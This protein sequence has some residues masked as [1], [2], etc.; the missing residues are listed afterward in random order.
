MFVFR[1]DNLVSAIRIVEAGSWTKNRK[2]CVKLM[3]IAW[4]L[5]TIAQFNIA[6]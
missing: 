2:I 5:R 3:V 6:D 1:S 4:I